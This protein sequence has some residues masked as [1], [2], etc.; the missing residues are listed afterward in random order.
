M[1]RGAASKLIVCP[2]QGSFKTV[3]LNRAADTYE[4]EES[5]AAVLRRLAEGSADVLE[6]TPGKWLE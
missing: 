5:D 6:K 1:P 2:E 3:R 4:P